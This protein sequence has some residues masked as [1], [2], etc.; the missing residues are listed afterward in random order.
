MPEAI[1]NPFPVPPAAKEAIAPAA[2]PASD[3]GGFAT[4]LRDASSETAP[5]VAHDEGEA[6]AE[7]ALEGAEP[8]AEEPDSGATKA[9]DEAPGEADGVSDEADQQ[10]V[11]APSA[12]SPQVGTEATTALI[13][14]VAAPNGAPTLT[15]EGAKAVAS[16]T[17]AAAD[18]TAPQTKPTTSLERP[19]TAT[20]VTPKPENAGAR[21]QQAA[22]Q[23][24][25]A[26]GPA[27]PEVSTSAARSVSDG[28]AELGDAE[29]VATSKPVQTRQPEAVNREASASSA[30]TAPG[31]EGDFTGATD[32]G[33]SAGGEQ[34]QRDSER[35]PVP[36]NTPTAATNDTAA[37]P[38]TPREFVGEPP[39]TATPS[40]ETTKAEPASP[41]TDS[42]RPAATTV[43]P[44]SAA[45]AREATQAG[46]PAPA[47]LQA[48]AP[49]PPRSVQQANE[50]IT[51]ASVQRGLNAALA[52]R[53]GEM[54]IRLAPESLGALRISMSVTGGV[55]SASF[56]ADSAEAVR[57]LRAGLDG[58][59][60]SIEARGLQVDRLRI[61]TTHATNSV[62]EP[63]DAKSDQGTQRRDD[64]R[65]D[66]DGRSRGRG[67][68]QQGGGERQQRHP[69]H[70]RFNQQW[71][72][73]LDATA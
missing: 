71:K 64:A 6:Q 21:H 62:A 23:S 35:P 2:K 48:E 54:T 72:L 44:A 51:L 69:E 50:R 53:G 10:E 58:L 9:A 12:P 1:L 63:G 25:T 4:V 26:N 55:V 22:Q 42:T 61:A 57:T 36:V 60:E 27:V 17:P 39:P 18:E 20:P 70:S 67:D 7:T 68:R 47:P 43:E 31:A 11:V 8:V 46:R 33:T 56:T 19:V 13:E 16:S 52:Q 49:E 41:S 38:V 30:V 32:D 45:P 5:P 66:T 65:S 73:A 34:K 3:D 29:P 59:R 28:S 15:D 37:P 40:A 14:G 24:D